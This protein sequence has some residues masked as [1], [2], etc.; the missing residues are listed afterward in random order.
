MSEP[1]AL[2]VGSEVYPVFVALRQALEAENKDA[3]LI[4][5]AYGFRQSRRD[6]APGKKEQIIK[7][8]GLQPED[9]ALI[10]GMA[11]AVA[12]NDLAPPTQAESFTVVESFANGGLR[13]LEPLL[14]DRDLFLSWLTTEVL[15][16]AEPAQVG[17]PFATS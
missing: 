12:D 7:V 9:R 1:T 10:A 3:F 11:L 16:A 8:S 6:D 4:A 14:E 13:L 17:W 15:S 2:Y 5:A